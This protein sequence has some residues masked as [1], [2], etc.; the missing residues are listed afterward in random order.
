DGAGQGQRAGGL[1]DDQQR[2]VS[3]AG[4]GRAGEG[5][6]S[7]SVEQEGGSPAGGVDGLADIPGGGD[8]ARAI[9]APGGQAQ[10]SRHAEGRAGGYRGRRAQVHRVQ[11][12]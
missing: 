3:A 12:V 10:R 5:L 6:R 4:G 1:V 8:G 2:Q 11:R 9:D 7:A